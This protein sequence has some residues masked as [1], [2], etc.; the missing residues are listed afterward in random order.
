MFKV[1]DADPDD[2]GEVLTVQRAA[3]LSEAAIYQHF[4]LPPLTETLAGI[5]A[6]IAALTVLK[7]VAGTRIVGA[8]RGRV[9]GDTCYVGRL[10]VAPD[11][12]GQGIG[13]AL[14]RAIEDRFPAVP[15]FELFTGARSEANLRL[16]RRLGYVDLEPRPGD[17]PDL[18]Y[19][20]K[21]HTGPRGPA[22]HAAP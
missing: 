21:V 22:D 16:Y 9:E 11:L 6:A 19:L 12:Q 8:V 20:A 13:T 14:L 3:Y 15:R 7:A 2:A 4:G 1:V 5:R 17:H 18:S 10:A